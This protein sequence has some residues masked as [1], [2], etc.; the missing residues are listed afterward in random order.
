MIGRAVAVGGLV[1]A[2]SAGAASGAQGHRDGVV[3]TP[4]QWQ[5]FA[6]AVTGFDK[7]LVDFDKAQRRCLSVGAAAARGCRARADGVLFG[8]YGKFRSGVD[9]VV[10]GWP[11]TCQTLAAE[12]VASLT[13]S[14]RFKRRITAA[15]NSGENKTFAHLEYDSL[16]AEAAAVDYFT[17]MPAQCRG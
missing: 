9:R 13:R 12:V 16:L 11:G 8:A 4:L 1:L 15:L 14:F 3:L 6:G 2:V 7:A 10:A 5:A 17:S